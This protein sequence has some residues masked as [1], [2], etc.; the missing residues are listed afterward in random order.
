MSVCVDCI[1]IDLLVV[2][3]PG[4][5]S[6]VAS[7]PDLDNSS[8]I[9]VFF[10]NGK[11]IEDDNCD[12]EWTLLRYLRDKLGIR[13]TKLGCAEG[14]C[15]ACTVMV[16]RFE[17]QTSTV[18]HLS[19]NACLAL[20]ASMHGTAVTT[21]EGIGSTKNG[22]HAVQE[23]IARAHGSQCGFCT[24]GIVMS[25]YTLIRNTPNPTMEQIEE[26]FSGNLCRC[27][28][29][30]PILEGVRTFS[31]EAAVTNGCGKKNCCQLT[32]K[33]E[34]GV[35]GESN[36]DINNEKTNGNITEVLFD[37]SEFA[38]Y[39]PTQ[40]IIF[41]PELKLD[42]M[43]DN[44]NLEFCG[45]RVSFFRPT[46][47]THILQLKA[48]HP[49]AKLVVGNTEV[50]VEVKF[51]NQVYPVIINPSYVPE[52][53]D[54]SITQDGVEFGAAVTLS[55]I[56]EILKEEVKEKKEYS[57]RIFT[58]VLEMFRWFAGKQIRNAAAIGGNIMTGSPISDLNPLLMAAEAILTLRSTD[59]E[60]KV[61]MDGKFFTGYRRNIVDQREILVSILIP[62]TKDNEYFFGYKQA[63]RRDDDIAIVNAGMKVSFHHNTNKVTNVKLAF[64]GMAPTT[65]MANETMKELQGK[66]WDTS[67]LE[68][69]SDTLLKD[70]PL[71]PSVPGGMVE[72]RRALTLSFFFKFY[73][74][75]RGCLSAMVPELC[76]PLSEEESRAVELHK[77][78]DTK[79]TQIWQK[80]SPGQ[81]PIDPI[82][83]PLPHLA[84]LKQVTGEAV[85]I[86]DMPKY[87]NELYGALVLSTKPHAL[88]INIDESEA[89]KIKGVERFFCHRDLP[90]KRNITGSS[91]V[92]DEEVFASSKVTCVGQVIGIIVA[93][94]QST[95]QRA[96]KLVKVDYKEIHPVIITIQDAIEEKSWWDSWTINKGKVEEELSKAQHILEGE[97]HMGGQEQFY[98][99]TN[100]HLAVPL[101]E[102]GA[103]ELFSS[104][105]NPAKTQALVAKALGVPSSHV[106]CRV[107]RMGGGF[108]G[109][110]TRSALVSVPISVAAV[111]LN[112]PVRCMLDRDEDMIMTGGRHPFLSRWR[113]GFNDEGIVSALSI[114]LY[115]NCGCSMDLSVGVVHR[116][117]F[118][119]D[120]A[121]HIPNFRVTGYACKTNLPSN[122]AFRG[123]GGPQ[124]MLFA[125]EVMS[126]VAA[127]C[128][129]DHN[130]V[131]EH[132]LYKTGDLSHINTVL[133][134]CTVRDC[135]NEV[136]K[137]SDFD[138][139]LKAVH[140]FNKENKYVKRGLTMTP[141]KYGIAFGVLFLNQAGALVLVYTDG[142]VLLTHGGTEMGQ[143][144]HTKMIQVASRVLE[145]P[146]TRIHISETSTNTVPN[147]SPTAASASSDLNGGAVQN[148]CEI[149]MER[150][151][152]YK[153][154]NPNGS[155]DDWV[156]SAYFDRVSL[157]ATGFFKTPNITTFNF[158][159]N[160]GRPF[161]Y[162]SY[163]A[164][165][166]EVELD[167]LTG[168]HKV[169][170]TDIVMD[171][172]DSLNPAIDIGQ[173]EGAFVQG[174]GLFTLE[175]LRYSPQGVLLTRG[176]G[177]YKIPGFADIPR[178][179]NV[180]LLRNS[181]NPRAVFSSKAVGEPPLLLAASIFYALKQ[182]VSSVRQEQGVTDMSGP[183]AVFRM[184]SPATAERLRLACQDSI[185]QKIKPAE[186]GSFTPW[187]VTV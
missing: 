36:G 80:V 184:D 27:T 5:F 24:P 21:V 88:I 155:W 140:K 7:M 164:A 136:I 101:G 109:K 70:L 148:A 12:P 157:S 94:D 183:N 179:F 77:H 93:T 114:D 97:M 60:R 54:I 52:L 169:L 176:P 92:L 104:T 122:T 13:G 142:S 149:I 63:R 105:Q 66:C 2:V 81:L 69:A 15:G 87:N 85:Y 159:K 23:R 53:F 14:G 117:I 89:L 182:A 150:L 91:A 31:Q 127:F 133:E 44:Q 113:V 135:W 9:L 110:E 50:G 124:G 16:S 41:P 167:C 160:E 100:A 46:T 18:R 170:R 171:V 168:D 181:P 161:D 20:V 38:P 25:M 58:A 152:P 103:L 95:A 111:G 166:T 86:D 33:T 71:P 153:K 55:S 35:N 49:N 143:G 187:S 180:S 156:K 121:Y 139:R 19:V 120:N 102:D 42:S 175:E 185:T 17:R 78:I 22:L 67:L 65:V 62:Y 34:E 57:T 29:Y 116:A 82:G 108:G 173:I 172:G 90:G 146:Y 119:A 48:K 84:A 165:A 72:Y 137:N 99:E 43:L 130:L 154:S 123:F 3:L 174:Q 4:P 28:G 6:S 8:K 64:G 98:L 147:T 115:G 151:A 40:E 125:E 11:K 145:I 129:L 158:E 186:P 56:E 74:S 134:R 163:G 10:V 141:M 131:R 45:E 47:L 177:A 96:A 76:Q 26:N 178:E 59:G 73:L 75:V 51:K 1:L 39:D 61:V 37:P 68:L 83:R 107:K 138:I 112:R 132:N 30:R 128:G 126:R 162:Y 106:V 79:S 144:L 118:T 32:T